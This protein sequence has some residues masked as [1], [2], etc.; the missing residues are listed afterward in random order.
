MCATTISYDLNGNI[1][2]DGSKTY[3]YNTRNQLSALAGAAVA[4]FQYEGVGGLSYGYDAAGRRTVQSGTLHESFRAASTSANAVVDANNRL[5]SLSGVTYSYDNNG[6]LTSDGVR[7][8]LWDVRNR[9]SQIKQGATTLASFEYDPLGRRSKK[10]VSASTTQ[11]LHDGANAVQELNASNAV[12]A[13]VVGGLGL[14]SWYFRSEGAATRHFLTD[15][16][17]CTRALTDDAKAIQTRY[18]YEVFG[19]TTTSGVASTNRSQYTGRDNDG[20]GLYY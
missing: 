4:S 11:Y 15:A 14:D 9:L 18:Q 16:L 10:T 20:T 2:N 17:G 12:T 5:T 13:N 6:S 1:T 19:E 8:Y 3:A 7:T